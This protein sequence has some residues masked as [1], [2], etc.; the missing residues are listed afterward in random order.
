MGTIVFNGGEEHSRKLIPSFKNM[1]YVCRENENKDF[2]I[3]TEMTEDLDI[4]WYYDIN[5]STEESRGETFP[6]PSFDHDKPE[7]AL[8]DLYL[9]C[10][11]GN[12]G[13]VFQEIEGLARRHSIVCGS[14]KDVTVDNICFKYIGMHGIAAGGFV[15]NLTVTNC[16]FGWIGGCIQHFL[17]T[18]DE[19]T[20]LLASFGSPWLLILLIN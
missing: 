3:K 19:G 8:G 13:E 14:E 7:I 9:R 18:G 10:D 6:I 16:E 1:K 4:F 2:D 20:V 17:G 12:P 15:P 5:L 11:K